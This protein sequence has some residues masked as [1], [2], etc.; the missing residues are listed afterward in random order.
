MIKELNIIC[1]LPKEASEILLEIYNSILRERER[2]FPGDLGG[3]NM[4]N[5]LYSKNHKTNS[6]PLFLA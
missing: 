5:F 4:Y 1:S 3:K 2:V 6:R